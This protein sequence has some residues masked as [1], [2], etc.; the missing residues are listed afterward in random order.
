MA[1]A[2]RRVRDGLAGPG[3]IRRAAPGDRACRAHRERKAPGRQRHR[4][5]SRRNRQS[6]SHCPLQP[7]EILSGTQH[8]PIRAC[9]RR[10]TGASGK[11]R[12]HVAEGGE[13]PVAASSMSYK[14]RWTTGPARPLVERLAWRVQCARSTTARMR[15]HLDAF[16]R[17]LA[18]AR[19]SPRTVS[20]YVAVLSSLAAFTHA[21]GAAWPPTLR[22]ITEFVAR[23]RADGARR[24]AA[25]VN[26]EVAAVRAFAGFARSHLDWEGDPTAGLAFVREAPHDPAV[27]SLDELRRLFVAASRGA[28]GARDLAILAAL[29]QAGL[30]VHELV[31]LDV[32]QLDLASATLVG[33]HGKGDTVHDLPL[34]ERTVALLGAWLLERAARAAPA[35]PALFLSA[36]GSRLS[37]RGVQ[38][39]LTRLRDGIGT[40]KRLTPH[41]LRHACA[42]LALTLG[43]DVAVVSQLLRHARLDTT[44]RYLHL[45]DTQRRAAVGRLAV[46]IPPELVAPSIDPAPATSLAAPNNVTPLRPSPP[47][48]LDVVQRGLDDASRA[49]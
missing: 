36:R 37:V 29:S 30:R 14:P 26:Q 48:T 5:P 47:A 15:E 9:V 20:T 25:T 31:T 3:V 41:S 7:G 18:A 44:R 38:R 33:V 46:A 39:L 21:A 6:V 43:A 32:E 42:T 27:P 11:Y 8:A 22:V 40:T 4:G 12:A 19:R 49:A 1:L 16:E 10:I 17:H 23:P 24:A 13:T 28:D 45:V 2:D 34:N 35:E